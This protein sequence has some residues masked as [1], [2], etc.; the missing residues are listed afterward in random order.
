MPPK[1]QFA[2]GINKTSAESATGSC[3][4]T[5]ELCEAGMTGS[6]PALRDGLAVSIFN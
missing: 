3:M 6:Y 4:V 5:S 1:R 2:S